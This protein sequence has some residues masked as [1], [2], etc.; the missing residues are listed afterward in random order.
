MERNVRMADRV[1]NIEDVKSTVDGEFLLYRNRPLVREN[2][3]I[4][5]GDLAEKYYIK[6]IVMTEKEYKGAKV[7]DQIYLQLLS[8]DSSLPQS[9]RVVK[10][11]MKSGLSDAL[12]LGVAWLE[13]YLEATN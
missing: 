6:M 10:A 8:T 3:V 4:C 12:E 13:R 1:I 11:I 5:Y 7:P 9:Q 2:N